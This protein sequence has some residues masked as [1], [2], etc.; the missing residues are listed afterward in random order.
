M[1]L[2]AALAE[3]EPVDR[4]INATSHWLWGRKAGRHRGFDLRYTAVG[5]AS[6]ASAAMFW[7]AVF[8]LGLARRQFAGS[9]DI[10]RD[11]PWGAS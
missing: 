11:A 7:G 4:P 5:A 6:N 9:A 2:A 3:G 1:L 8:G 10:A